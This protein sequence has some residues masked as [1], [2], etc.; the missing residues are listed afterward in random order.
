[1]SLFVRKHL[2]SAIEKN[3]TLK[4]PMRASPTLK[5]RNST[6]PLHLSPR[7][8]GTVGLITCRR[9]TSCLLPMYSNQIQ[10]GSSA[11]W[12]N[13]IALFWSLC[14]NSRKS[15]S[16]PLRRPPLPGGC[17]AN[18]LSVSQHFARIMCSGQRGSHQTD[19]TASM[20][21]TPT[22][23]HMLTSGCSGSRSKKMCPCCHTWPAYNSFAHCIP[24]LKAGC[25]RTQARSGPILNRGRSPR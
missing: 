10:T 11:R 12:C 24:L 15:A 2:K 9:C 16:D 23:A 6:C 25:R 14:H 18:L 21:K 20:R 22:H 17:K 3:N 7:H 5:A 13:T 4:L 8:P 1:V 19:P